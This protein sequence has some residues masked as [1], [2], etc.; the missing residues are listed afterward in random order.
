MTIMKTTL[1]RVQAEPCFPLRKTYKLV[2]FD[3]TFQEFLQWLKHHKLLMKDLE[4]YRDPYQRRLFIYSHKTIKATKETVCVTRVS[5]KGL[6][7]I[8][9]RLKKQAKQVKQS[10]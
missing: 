5:I 2:Q 1:K 7:F 10:V 3:G 4:P 9:Q 6:Y 8:K